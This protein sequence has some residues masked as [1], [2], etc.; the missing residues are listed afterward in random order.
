MKRKNVRRFAAVL[1]AGVLTASLTGCGTQASAT[2]AEVS[3]ETETIIVTEEDADMEETD[4]EAETDEAE[5][6]KAEPV[7]SEHEYFFAVEEIDWEN[8]TEEIDMNALVPFS[9]KLELDH[10]L[11]LYHPEGILIGYTK[12]DVSLEV[13]T[14]NEDWYCVEFEDEEEDF[15]YLLVKTE[16]VENDTGTEAR[17]FITQ[18]DVVAAFNEHYSNAERG[19]EILDARSFDMEFMEFSVSVTEDDLE[20]RMYGWEE[21]LAAYSKFYIEPLERDYDNAT[22]YFQVYYKEPRE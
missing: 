1:T 19:F 17:E 7:Y 8:V 22:L 20:S 13:L 3:M 12:P 11:D 18:E 5:G 10:S 2:D 15:R 14:Y 4:V 16:D 21:N 6:V 9:Q